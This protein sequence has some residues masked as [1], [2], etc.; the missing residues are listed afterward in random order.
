MGVY[1]RIKDSIKVLLG[2]ADAKP[3]VRSFI[4]PH[5]NFCCTVCQNNIKKF[6]PLPDY[7]Y[8]QLSESCFIHPVFMA[9]TLN[10]ISYSCPVCGASDRDRLIALF[11]KKF[12]A[13]KENEMIS[14]LDIAPSIPLQK[15]IKNMF[16]IINYRSADL[17]M[18]G[19]DDNLD[20]TNMYLYANDQF[21]F[22]ICSHVLEHVDNDRKAIS[23]L[24][25]VL[26]PEA[27]AI[28]MVP[29]FLHLTDDYENSQITSP[30]E[31]WR[32]FGQDDHV[33]MYSKKG[34]IEKL[35]TAGFDVKEYGVDEFSADGFF[36]AGITKQSVLYVAR[37]KT[38]HY[39]C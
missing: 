35:E 12:Y 25:R 34:F 22:I 4:N 18:T 39:E 15:L 9:E 24:F 20:I 38:H 10:F 16:K 23:E 3:A 30:T 21:D 2:L 5:S 14:F 19:V 31:R 7:F 17:K 8:K 33:R 1:I 29:V 27:K 32:H 26:K 37:K 11:L 28:I 6:H 13:D 36:K